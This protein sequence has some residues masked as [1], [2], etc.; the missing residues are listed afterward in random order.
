[1]MV[2]SIRMPPPSEALNATHARPRIRAALVNHLVEVRERVVGHV[3]QVGHDFDRSFEYGL[4]LIL[5]ALESRRAR[6]ERPGLSTGAL[7]PGALPL[8]RASS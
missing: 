4:D 5:D 3:A 6:D 7:G 8:G 2:A 1:M